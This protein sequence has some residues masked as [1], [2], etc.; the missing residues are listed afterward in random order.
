MSSSH[1]LDPNSNPP[2]QIKTR[3]KLVGTN[4]EKEG[5]PCPGCFNEQLILT[6]SNPGCPDENRWALYCPACKWRDLNLR[7]P[8]EVTCKFCNK[9]FSTD[10]YG[11]AQR[12]LLRPR[13]N[14][15]PQCW[16]KYAE[17]SWLRSEHTPES[18][19]PTVTVCNEFH[20]IEPQYDP[21]RD[22]V[23]IIDHE[24]SAI[25]EMSKVQFEQDLHELWNDEPH[26]DTKPHYLSVPLHLLTTRDQIDIARV[27]TERMILI[28][29]KNADYGS[30]AFTPPLLAPGMDPR[31]ALLVR[32]SDKI[33][34][35]INL[36]SNEAN[37]KEETQAMTV[38]D[39]I[40]YCILWL[41]DYERQESPKKCAELAESSPSP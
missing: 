12:A 35:F 40:G 2:I 10:W 29:K 13:D 1:P 22:H 31:A 26:P 41:V 3:I 21:G 17:R 15:C 27:A 20:T 6:R 7:E 39:I 28:L 37:V 19:M 8:V 25:H 38:D 23:V 9:G 16:P 5:S 18:V 4:G 14:V 11:P 24:Q 36:E 34:R 32:L 30:S 33:Q